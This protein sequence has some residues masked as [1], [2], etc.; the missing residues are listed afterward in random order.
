MPFTTSSILR[1]HFLLQLHLYCWIQSQHTQR[2]RT[3]EMLKRTS[4]SAHTRNSAKM[5]SVTGC[6]DTYWRL[7]DYKICFKDK[8]VSIA[9]E[10]GC[11][12]KKLATK[13]HLVELK[14]GTDRQLLCYVSA[15]SQ[16]CSRSL[17]IDSVTIIT[18]SPKRSRALYA[19]S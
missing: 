19:I 8:L 10:A 9:E 18:L 1:T 6:Y 7:D 13:A 4:K 11:A 5:A 12:V 15:R 17:A 16:S 14:H 3:L 2:L